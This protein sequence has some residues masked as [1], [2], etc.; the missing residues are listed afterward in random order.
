MDIFYFSGTGNSLHIARE[1]QNRFPDARLVPIIRGLKSAHS[2]PDSPGTHSVPGAHSSQDADQA[3]PAEQA[4]E[5]TQAASTSK[6]VGF[7]FPI[8]LTDM[9][10]PVRD[11]IESLSVDSAEYIF[12]AATRISTY[13]IADIRLQRIL[14]KKGKSLDAFF[15]IDMARNSPCG[16]VPKFFPGFKKMVDSW[17]GSFAPEK[18]QEIDTA[19]QRRLDKICAAIETRRRHWDGK[20]LL[21][22]TGKHL[23]TLLMAPMEK[24]TR[25]QTIPFFA[26]ADCTGCGL[27]EE[28][29]L[30]G[31]V[32]LA[33]GRPVWQTD[34]P[35][36]F[37]Y[38]CFNSC[39]EQAI[40]IQDKYERKTGRYL[41]PGI[42]PADIA[43]QK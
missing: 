23:N 4:S 24:S 37:C 25:K 21:S 26:D 35:C 2:E 14:R 41:H 12:A 19:A 34:V 43:G 5:N 1:I 11:F 6:I 9:P 32:V 3:E 39:P 20:N 36:F 27:C 17:A 15:I 42:T 7:V 31:R 16:L 8:H 10:Y 33:D 38:A 22:M 40:L 30:S 13:Y 18:L 28:V 29:C